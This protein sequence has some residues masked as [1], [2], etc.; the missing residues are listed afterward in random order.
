MS[1][2]GKGLVVCLVKFTA[3]FGDSK[4]EKLRIL[5][6]YYESDEEKRR[7][8]LQENP[9]SHTNYGRQFHDN[10]RFMI[11]ELL[12]IYH[13]DLDRFVSHEIELWANGATDHL[14]E[15][16]TP[17]GI[18]WKEVK[19]KVDELKN[20]GLNMGHGFERQN[21][22]FKDL[23]ELWELTKGVSLLID[24]KIGLKPEIG[25]YQ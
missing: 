3:H 22:N 23:D 18:K 1:E 14:Y 12:P 19:D 25:T 6:L 8:L 15:I 7:L 16:E 10:L 20:K 17:K 9:P 5:R 13:G 24:K 21:Y 2:F 4:M 11:N